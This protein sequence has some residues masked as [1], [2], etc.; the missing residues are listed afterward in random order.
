M[1]VEVLMF[2]PMMVGVSSNSWEFFGKGACRALH[3][4]SA[5]PRCNF[6]LLQTLSIAVCLYSTDIP[7]SR[8]SQ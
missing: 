1:C 7:E 5:D 3:P 8:K 4:Q 6:Q 2:S